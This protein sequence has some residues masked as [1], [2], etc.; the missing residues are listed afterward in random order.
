MVNMVHISTK[1]IF[2]AHWKLSNPPALKKN[3]N[4]FNHQFHQQQAQD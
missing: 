2:G 4:F 1:R 3:L